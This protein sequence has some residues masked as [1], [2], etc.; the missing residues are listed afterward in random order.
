VLHENEGLPKNFYSEWF[1]ALGVLRR[2]IW[3]NGET[4]LADIVPS[5]YRGKVKHKLVFSEL[6]SKFSAVYDMGY[7]KGASGSHLALKQFIL[8]H[9]IP[10]MLITDGDQA[11]NFSQ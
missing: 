4:L 1:Q 5:D 11:E 7:S 9:G 6:N 2:M 3:Q 10:Q 8:D